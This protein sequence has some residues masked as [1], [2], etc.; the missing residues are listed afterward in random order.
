M[1]RLIKLAVMHMMLGALLFSLAACGKA[2]NSNVYG[3]TVGGLEDDALFAIIEANAKSPVLLVTNQ[4]FED[5]NG[6]RAAA[7]CDVYYITGGSVKQIGSLESLGT[8][9]PV[10]YDTSGI[11]VGSGH[12]VQRYEINDADGSLVLAEEITETFDEN[13]NAAYTNT[14]SENTEIISEQDFLSAM[15]SFRKATVVN[16][17]YGAT[18]A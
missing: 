8:A 6:N 5:G 16:F 12:S 4:T 15:E 7:S 2:D 3:S 1:N 13:G 11:Y 17:S 10:S 9:Y 14:I 18:G